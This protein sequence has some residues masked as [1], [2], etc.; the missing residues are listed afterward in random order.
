M[1]REESSTGVI[2]RLLAYNALDGAEA[3]TH[4]EAQPFIV[5]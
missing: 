4:T 3:T 5:R 2:H 1:V